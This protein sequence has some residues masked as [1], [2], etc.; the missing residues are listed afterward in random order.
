MLPSFRYCPKHLILMITF[1][2]WVITSIFKRKLESRE[3]AQH[4]R[5]VPSAATIWTWTGW[6]L[7]LRIIRFHIGQGFQPQHYW[8]IR[9]D[10]SFLWGTLLCIAGYLT[11]SLDSVH[12]FLWQSKMSPGIANVPWMANPLTIEDWQ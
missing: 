5:Y 4:H 9:M 2:A 10:N 3:T 11:A 6:L 7:S 1:Y 8:H 12:L